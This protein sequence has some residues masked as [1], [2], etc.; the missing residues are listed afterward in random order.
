MGPNTKYNLTDT[1]NYPMIIRENGT[2]KDDKEIE[3]ELNE[4]YLKNKNLEDT[5]NNKNNASPIKDIEKGVVRVPMPRRSL[6]ILYGPARYDWEHGILRE[7]IPSRRVCIT[8]REL[9]PTY[10]SYGPKVEIGEHILKA[11]KYFWDHVKYYKLG[12]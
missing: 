2:V 3:M 5:K 12:T 6:L 10:L 1:K 4:L 9:T 7:D 8:Y 11:S